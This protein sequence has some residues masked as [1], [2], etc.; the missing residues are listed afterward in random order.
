[1]KL[2]KQTS[3][4]LAILTRCRASGDRLVKV[5]D[6]AEAL[7]LTRQMALKLANRLSRAGLV[8]TVRGPRGGI[9][10]ADGIADMPLGQIVRRVEAELFGGEGEGSAGEVLLGFQ[11]DAAMDAFLGVLDQ[12]TLADLG[13]DDTVRAPSS[14]ED[15]PSAADASPAQSPATEHVAPGSGHATVRAPY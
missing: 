3:D 12:I 5:G 2:N 10:L 11:F 13:A 15:A 8:A 7:G 6:V 4:S 1:M 14:A 9:R